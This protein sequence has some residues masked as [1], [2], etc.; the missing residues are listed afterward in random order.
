MDMEAFKKAMLFRYPEII[1]MGVHIPPAT[2]KEHRNELCSLIQK[3]PSIFGDVHEIT[4]Q[5]DESLKGYV[6]EYTDSWGCVWKNLGYGSI[7]KGHPVPKREDVHRLCIPEKDE[8]IGHGFMYLRLIDLRGYEEFMIDIAEEPP[9]LQI[10][11]DKVLEYNL[12]QIRLLLQKDDSEMIMLADDL[13]MQNGLPMS[14]EKWRKYIRPCFERIF[15]LCRKHNRYVYMHT[16]GQIYQLIDDLLECGLNAIGPQ[17]RANGLDNLVKYCKGRIG[18]LLDLDRQ[19]LP[20][21]SKQDIFD[22]VREIIENFWL[23]EGGIGIFTEFPPDMSPENMESVCMA[24]EK[25]M[26]FQG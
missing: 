22:H 7:V 25:Y 12:R 13:G 2:W 19:M 5:L 1:P 11:I 14:L 24:M 21:C 4:R 23:P 9:E 8:G 16:D 15:G 18:V 10:L 17:F 26:Y 6:E 3:F 20:F